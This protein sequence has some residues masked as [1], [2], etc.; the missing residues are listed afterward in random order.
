M[1]CTNLLPPYTGQPS[2]E[3]LFVSN[4]MH[5]SINPTACTLYDDHAFK[6]WHQRWDQRKF[7]IQAIHVVFE[8]TNFL[9]YQ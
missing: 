6:V 8:T 5:L 7:T 4:L 2:V 9:S 3:S 1:G